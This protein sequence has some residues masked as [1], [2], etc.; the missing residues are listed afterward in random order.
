MSNINIYA[1]FKCLYLCE[2]PPWFL[3]TTV[4]RNEYKQFKEP[5]NYFP[6][7]I[8][9]IIHKLKKCA[10]ELLLDKNH[11]YDTVRYKLSGL[12]IVITYFESTVCKI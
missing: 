6:P 2:K 10:I 4:A 5:Y 11:K 8:Y 7:Q 3:T 9:C 1:M 12:R